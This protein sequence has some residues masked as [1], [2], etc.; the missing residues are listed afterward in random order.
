MKVWKLTGA[1]KLVCSEEPLPEHEDGKVRVRVTKVLVNSLDADLYDGTAPCKYPLIPGRYAV[2]VIAEDGAGAYLPRGARVLL[3]TFRPIAPNG[4]SKRDFASPEFEI[5]GLTRD[6]FITDFVNVSPDFLTALPP[7]VSDE[8]ALLLHHVAIAK[9]ICDALES[10][11]GQHI[12]VVGANLVGILVC[13]LLI[14]QQAA[15]ILV[16]TMQHHLDFAKKC[17]VYYTVLADNKALENVASITGG[18]LADGA[19]YV[20][21]AIGNAPELPFRLAARNSNVVIYGQPAGGL[22]V[23]LDLAIRKHLA[24]Y[25]VE[26]G[27]GYLDTAINLMANKAVDISPYKANVVKAAKA[28]SLFH[29]YPSRAD[30]GSDIVNFLDLM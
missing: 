7:S 17:G 6:G 11:K 19:V 3:H 9:A 30:R 25:C 15:P 28:A 5:C 20:S 27:F 29:D 12:V 1:K 4:T 21:S 18:R 14:Y 16:D 2:G 13:Q 10:K 24:I 22:K 23:R 8:R 26:N